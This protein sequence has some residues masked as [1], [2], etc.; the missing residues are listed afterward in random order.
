M[1]RSETATY[2]QQG[3]YPLWKAGGTIKF[4]RAS[5]NNPVKWSEPHTVLE[6]GA[7]GGIP[8]VQPNPIT[9]LLASHA[10]YMRKDAMG[11]AVL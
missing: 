7:N 8:K 3:Q 9:T 4:A 5:V 1:R 10:H 2:S 6:E 11:C